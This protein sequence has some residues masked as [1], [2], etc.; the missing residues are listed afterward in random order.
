MPIVSAS[1]TSQ[2]RCSNVIEYRVTVIDDDVVTPLPVARTS[3]ID[4]YA[5]HS[6]ANNQRHCMPSS[7]LWGGRGAGDWVWRFALARILSVL[8]V[9]GAHALSDVE[10]R[11]PRG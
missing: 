2:V 3:R 9:F 6:V 10:R 1:H 7:R 11:T 8:L 4:A 5:S